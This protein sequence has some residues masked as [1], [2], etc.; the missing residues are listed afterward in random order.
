M[1]ERFKAE[2]GVVQ[3]ASPKDYSGSSVWIREH[4]GSGRP[5]RGGKPG[6]SDGNGGMSLEVSEE[7]KV[8]R[9]C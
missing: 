2:R 3:F 6:H 8:S 1:K 7:V 4:P 9:N 5:D